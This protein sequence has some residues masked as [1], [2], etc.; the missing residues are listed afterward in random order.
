MLSN[1]IEQL[2]SIYATHGDM[3]I[4]SG[5]LDE[6]T[7]YSWG[8][9]IPYKYFKC[10]TDISPILT[11]ISTKDYQTSNRIETGIESVVVQNHNELEE[12]STDQIESLPYSII[13]TLHNEQT[14]Q[15]LCLQLK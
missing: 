7:T 13:K 10:F 6:K 12:F 14:K 1:L 11:Q 3:P 8:D 5:H 2:Q 9:E 15:V 4:I